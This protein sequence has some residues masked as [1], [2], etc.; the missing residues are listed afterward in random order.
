MDRLRL[1]N[2]NEIM[3][4]SNASI[5]Y[6]LIYNFQPLQ[7]TGSDIYQS[8]ADTVVGETEDAYISLGNLVRV[9][10]VSLQH[11]QEI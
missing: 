5:F 1:C 10:I 3:F 4:L 11:P 7:L 9:K 8:I 6:H 2:I